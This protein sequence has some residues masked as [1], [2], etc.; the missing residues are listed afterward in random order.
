MPTDKVIPDVQAPARPSERG[1]SDAEQGSQINNGE[2]GLPPEKKL[3]ARVTYKT[4]QL[5]ETD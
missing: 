1:M 5:P 2:R 4:G 3:P